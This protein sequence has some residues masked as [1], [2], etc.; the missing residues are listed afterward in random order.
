MF[1]QYNFPLSFLFRFVLT[2]ISTV[3]VYSTKLYTFS[4]LVS[5]LGSFLSFQSQ[6]NFCGLFYDKSGSHR[7]LPPF[8]DIEHDQVNVTSFFK[9][10]TQPKY[11]IEHQLTVIKVCS[12]NRRLKDRLKIKRNSFG[13]GVFL[14][15]TF[16][17][18]PVI[19][20]NIK[21]LFYR[22]D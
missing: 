11:I 17:W 4:H 7:S 19:K 14:F 21:S 8:H 22:L 9:K 15:L 3:T 1:P 16:S 10:S 20:M 6:R 18:N 13:G 5:L 2:S 12:T